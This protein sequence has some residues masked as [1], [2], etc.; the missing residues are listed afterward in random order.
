MLLAA[1]RGTRI[2]DDIAGVPKCTLCVG[3]KPL[4]EHTE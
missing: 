3:G 1:G 2:K 4:I